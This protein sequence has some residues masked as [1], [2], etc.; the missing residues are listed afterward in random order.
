MSTPPSDRQI[1]EAHLSLATKEMESAP[2]DSPADFA[3]ERVARAQALA[4]TATAWA[5]LDIANVLRAG[6]TEPTVNVTMNGLD[7]ANVRSVAR[8][9]ADDVKRKL[10]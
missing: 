3:L 9:I 4:T 1:A 6:L 7:A 5:L 8:S 10:R 2:H